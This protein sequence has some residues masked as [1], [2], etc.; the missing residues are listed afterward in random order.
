MK[1]CL[2]CGSS[3]EI[4]REHI[5][6]EW[7]LGELGLN[8]EEVTMNHVTILG[9][10]KSRR[11]HIFK[12]LVNAMICE[13]CNT[14][15]MSKLETSVKD[16][17]IRLMNLD[18]VNEDLFKSLNDNYKILAKWS[19]K[20]AIVL[21]YPTNYRKIVPE[22]HFQSLYHSKIPEG[23]YINMAFTENE[24]PLHWHQSQTLLWFFHTKKE[25]QKIFSRSKEIYKI[26][27][28][29]KHLLLRVCY[30]PFKNFVQD[31]R[32]ESSIVLWPEF[33]RYEN[34]RIYKDIDEFDSK[35]SFREI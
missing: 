7:L 16:L 25:E 23:V 9:M 15:W 19:F 34:F 35:A 17:I 6:P 20:T 12:S 30:F 5:F 11:S 4:S 31:D 13:K 28:Q 24:E 1:K 22:N 14:G 33:G 18:S 3:K 32:V 21:N 10:T 29:F 2:F 8:E 27:L 26:T